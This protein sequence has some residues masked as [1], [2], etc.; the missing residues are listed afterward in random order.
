MAKHK[1]N[2]KPR[3]DALLQ[4]ECIISDFEPINK[5]VLQVVYTDSQHRALY[6]CMIYRIVYNPPPFKMYS[7]AVWTLPPVARRARTFCDAFV[8]PI[9]CNCYH[10]EMRK[11]L[12]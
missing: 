10:N 9:S 4:I 2:A 1:H 6:G 8:K 5:Q 7:I 3:A 11:K 12:L